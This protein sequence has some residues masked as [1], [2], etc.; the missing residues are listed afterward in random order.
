MVPYI[1]ASLS[2]STHCRFYRI[3]LVLELCMVSGQYA[4]AEQSEAEQSDEPSED[5][6]YLLSVPRSGNTWFRYCLEHTLSAPS[7][8][9]DGLRP[10]L[11][12]LNAGFVY[13]H[14]T[15]HIIKRH[16]CSI[17]GPQDCVQ[18]CKRLILLLRDPVETFLRK[19]WP[20]DPE[21]KKWHPLSRIMH[22]INVFLGWDTEQ[23]LLVRYE[24]LA[25]IQ[26]R[27]RSRSSLRR[28]LHKV[29]QFLG[30]D[31]DGRIAAFVRREH[32][33]R[34]ASIDM[35]TQEHPAVNHHIA[36]PLSDQRPLPVLAKLRR[37][38]QAELRKGACPA[39]NW[40]IN[41]NS[42][43]VLGLDGACS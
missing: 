16:W 20:R 15:A 22:V 1:R 24:S 29:H 27:S 38:I 10:L 13:L 36:R 30:L 14:N 34:R 12:Q 7:L 9:I 18:G 41:D 11:L 21:S 28:E 2:Y 32:H 25:G 4:R 26:N 19:S 39:L 17:G 31:D 23:R 3:G 5:C 43:I 33:H 6:A 8:D 40:T 42:G 37:Y 35:Y